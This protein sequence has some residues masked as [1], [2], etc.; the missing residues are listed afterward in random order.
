[1][2]TLLTRFNKLVRVLS[3]GCDVKS[4][5]SCFTLILQLTR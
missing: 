2:G 5:A 1:M 3:N 4:F